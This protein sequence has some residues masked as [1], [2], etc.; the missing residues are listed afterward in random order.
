MENGK[1]GILPKA[2]ETLYLVSLKG[3]EI[4]RARPRARNLAVRS[5][6]AQETGWGHAGKQELITDQNFPIKTID[7]STRRGLSLEVW[8]PKLEGGYRH[9]PPTPNSFVLH[10]L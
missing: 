2:E 9:L 1:I 7:A 10:H 6:E 4:A 5:G 3:L 8:S